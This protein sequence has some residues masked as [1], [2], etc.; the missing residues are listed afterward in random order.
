MHNAEFND[1][2]RGSLRRETL[3]Y[4][5]IWKNKGTL[6]G[7]LCAAVMTQSKAILEVGAT[8]GNITSVMVNY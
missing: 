1:S 3:T 7:D 4:R 5:A 2:D 6:H 8:W